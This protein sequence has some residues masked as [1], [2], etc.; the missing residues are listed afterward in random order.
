MIF[1][2]QS[3]TKDVH[4]SQP[5]NAGVTEWVRF[6]VQQAQYRKELFQERDTFPVSTIRAAW[7][8]F[9]F[10]WKNRTPLCTVCRRPSHAAYC[11]AWDPPQL[12]CLRTRSPALLQL[13]RPSGNYY[14]AW[15]SH[16]RRQLTKP[17]CPTSCHV[18][19]IR[20]LP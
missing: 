13:Q 20:K 8:A 16:N 19:G 1:A 12:H 6:K 10:L 14:T 9:W 15:W 3:S 5:G 2:F 4:I 18:H 17:T 11:T 7:L